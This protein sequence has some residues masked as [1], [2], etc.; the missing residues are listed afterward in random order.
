MVFTELY[1][2]FLSPLSCR[3]SRAESANMVT[4]Q[5]G[6]YRAGA[7]GGVAETVPAAGLARYPAC[8]SLSGHPLPVYGPGLCCNCC[9]YFSSGSEVL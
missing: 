2:V 9:G 4:T 7:K 3:A 8:A 6:R 5:H 1:Y